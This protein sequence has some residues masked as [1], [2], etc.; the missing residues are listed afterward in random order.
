MRLKSSYSFLKAYFNYTGTG[1][2]IYAR[3]VSEAMKVIRETAQENNLKPI[4]TYLHKQFS[5]KLTKDML[6]R[7]VSQAMLQYQD[8]FAEI[9]YFN[10]MAVIDKS[11]ITTKHRGIE[12]PI[13][14]VW[15]KKNKKLIIFTFSQPNNM[16]EELRVIKGLIKE[17]A[18]AGHLP[19]DIKTAA[20]WDLSKGKIAEVDYQALQ[21]VDRQRLIDAANRIK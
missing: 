21:T 12:I 13:E 18:P 4:Q 6:I 15:D 17:F 3:A 14:G 19:A 2:R 10:T 9:Q 7:L 16:R 20:Y 8:P 11:F 5:L 1:N